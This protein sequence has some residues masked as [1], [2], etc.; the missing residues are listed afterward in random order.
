MSESVGYHSLK[1]QFGDKK[2]NGSVMI[3]FWTDLVHITLPLHKNKLDFFVAAKNNLIYVHKSR[4]KHTD[5]T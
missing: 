3:Q 4:K 5:A 2:S 1:R